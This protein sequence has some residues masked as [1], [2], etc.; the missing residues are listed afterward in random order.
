M[1]VINLA[2]LRVIFIWFGMIALAHAMPSVLPSPPSV[3]AAAYVLM[4][5]NSGKLLASQDPD[6]QI[7][8]AS[9]TKMMTMYVVD[10]EIKSGKIKLTDNVI[11]SEK[12]WRTEG[13]K[14]FVEANKEVPVADLIRGIIIQ[15]GNDSSIALAEHIAGT[16][17]AFAA[18]M[19]NY[20]KELKMDSTHFVNATGL[21]NPDHYTTAHDLARLSQALIRD[22]PESYKLY[23]EKWFTYQNIKQPNRNRLLWREP[24]VDGIKTGHSDSAGYCL[25]A[26][27]IKDGMR[28]ISILVGTP[29]DGARTEQ[30]QQ[31]LRYG[32][33]FFETKRLFSQKDT[34]N[35]SR[36]WMGNAKEIKL[37]IPTDF[38]V[39]VP[40][41]EYSNLK[42][43]VNFS[44]R[45]TAPIKHGDVVGKII[46]TLNDE[47]IGERPL[48]AQQDVDKGG[49]W[50]RASDYFSLGLHKL[51]NSKEIEPEKS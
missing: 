15:S 25:A 29:S 41:G 43:S 1:K 3:Q 12:A 18:I 22:F 46:V 8:P 16:E 47:L 28:L 38:Y 23:S 20:A 9:L 5:F 42:T 33:R 44:E 19:N 48:I 36:I 51:F 27:G 39:T 31:L 50:D 49:I 13:S 37:G 4:D 7:D 35:Q 26:S 32:F 40:Q 2:W 21:P 11:I 34:V 45:L 24:A 17:E 30:T 10:Q 6:K 14:M